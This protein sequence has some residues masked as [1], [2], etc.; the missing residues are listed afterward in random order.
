MHLGFSV[1]GVVAQ[2]VQYFVLCVFKDI[3]VAVLDIDCETRIGACIAALCAFKLCDAVT[4]KA[5][6]AFVQIG[7]PTVQRLEQRSA[8]LFKHVPGV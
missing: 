4:E 2:P 7:F 1:D 5:A 3:G 8:A 6:R